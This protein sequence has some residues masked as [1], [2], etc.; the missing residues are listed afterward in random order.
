M[1]IRERQWLPEC[2]IITDLNDPTVNQIDN[3]LQPGQLVRRVR[4]VT[5]VQYL[6]EG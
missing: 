5:L 4:K 3:G 2:G 6:D 1:S